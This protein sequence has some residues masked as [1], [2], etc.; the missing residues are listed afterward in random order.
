M[1]EYLILYLT[2]RIVICHTFLKM[3]SLTKK[4]FSIK[5]KFKMENA[6]IIELTY[7]KQKNTYNKI[8][9]NN[10]IHNIFFII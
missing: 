9:V 10:K 5:K 3:I 8:I 7:K 6:A 2:I 4:G 1:E